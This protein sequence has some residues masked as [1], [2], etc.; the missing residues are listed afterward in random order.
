MKKFKELSTTDKINVINLGIVVVPV[1]VGGIAQLVKSTLFMD[2]KE[3]KLYKYISSI[4]KKKGYGSCEA[5]DLVRESIKI[6]IETKSDKY[7]EVLIRDLYLMNAR[8]SIL[9]YAH[10]LFDDNYIE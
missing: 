8:E 2:E 9:D 1:I 6:Y 4:V 7:L 5:D 3:K 10:K